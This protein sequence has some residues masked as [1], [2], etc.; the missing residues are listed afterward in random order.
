MTAVLAK[1]RNLQSFIDLVISKVFFAYVSSSFITI[2]D[3]PYFIRSPSPH[4]Y[5]CVYIPFA[6][7]LSSSH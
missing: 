3:I 7:L 5:V 2:K 4:T 6:N 1:V